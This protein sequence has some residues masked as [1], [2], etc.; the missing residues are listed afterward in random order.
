MTMHRRFMFGVAHGR[1]DDQRQAYHAAEII[2]EPVLVA[3]TLEIKRN[4]GRGAPEYGYRDRVGHADAERANVG[5]EQFGLYDGA[6]RGVAG[7]EKPG[8]AN[9]QEGHEWRF[10]LL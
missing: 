10:G 7:D 8:R 9:Q 5:G 3:E 2:I 6:D 1:V 4:R